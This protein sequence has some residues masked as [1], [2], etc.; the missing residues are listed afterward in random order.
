MWLSTLTGLVF[1]T[2]RAIDHGHSPDVQEVNEKAEGREI[3][4]YLQEEYPDEFEFSDGWY[5]DD[6]IAEVNQA[7][8][9]YAGGT[10]PAEY[11]VENNGLCYVVALLTEIIQSGDRW[12][13]GPA[14]RDDPPR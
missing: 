14:H 13:W 9:S 7:V 10:R 3:V 12:E 11:G 6:Q 1:Q 5:D 2:N 8:E 4:Q